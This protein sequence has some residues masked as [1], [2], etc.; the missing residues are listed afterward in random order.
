MMPPRSAKPKAVLMVKIDFFADGN[1]V[2]PCAGVDQRDKQN[3]ALANVVHAGDVAIF[4]WLA[5]DEFSLVQII[6]AS[7][8]RGFQSMSV[9]TN[10]LAAQ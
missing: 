9:M 2:L 1:G 7:C 10:C 8:Q 6:Q 3:V 5:V 4:N